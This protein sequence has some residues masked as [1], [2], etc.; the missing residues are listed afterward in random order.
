MEADTSQVR[1][2]LVNVKN[3]ESFTKRKRKCCV[4]AHVCSYNFERGNY[5]FTHFI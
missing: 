1:P 4:L 5:L 2:S 3:P